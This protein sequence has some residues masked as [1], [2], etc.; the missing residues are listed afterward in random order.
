MKFFCLAAGTIAFAACNSLATVVPYN[1]ECPVPASYSASSASLT[2]PTLSAPLNTAAAEAY[3]LIV[4]LIAPA[5]GE[6]DGIKG[7][8]YI[9]DVTI[10]ASRESVNHIIPFKPLFQ[11][12]SSSTFGAGPNAAFP[13]L[14]VLQNTTAKKG[15]LMGPNTN[16]A[17][18]FQLNGVAKT[19]GL[20]QYNPFWLAGAPAF[21]IGPSELVVY[22]VEGTAPKTATLTP[23]AADGLL[24]N[25]VSAPFTIS[26]RST[27]AVPSQIPACVNDQAYAPPMQNAS[28][29][30][31]EVT[32]QIFHP[33]PG[34]I[35]G[36]NGSGF[37]VD[38]AIDAT[39]AASN[40]LLSADSGYTSG[41]VSPSSPFF[42][43][44]SNHFLPGL[45][46]LFNTTMSATTGPFK[47][48]G[49]NLAGLFQINN[50]RLID[51]ATTIEIWAGWLVGKPIAG[52]G[53]SKVSIFV[54]N[55]TAPVYVDPFTLAARTDLIS[56]VY[57]VD[58]ILS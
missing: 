24:S 52:H 26:N 17:G 47:G 46:V 15:P 23:S 35:V 31:D 9:V 10:Q 20:N 6:I 44:G 28:S 29:N 50:A 5:A 19:Q 11:D 49:T 51:C 3:P 2:S 34:E 7:F 58:F 30:P 37:L 55:G 22:Y 4:T 40:V 27:N 33:S 41:F 36:V 42:H 57:T 8:D 32:I 1:N 45:V 54:V 48:P 13:G 14:V 12:S 38:I 43:P 18:L 21:G 25:I 39:S 16:L 53:A 56:S